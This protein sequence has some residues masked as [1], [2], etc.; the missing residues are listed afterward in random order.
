MSNPVKNLGREYLVNR[1]L[2]GLIISAFVF[3]VVYFSLY[4]FLPTSWQTPGSL[5]LYLIGVVGTLLLLV[6]ILFVFAK[7][8]INLGLPPVWYK[9]APYRARAVMDPR[10]VL[11][12]F[13]TEIGNGIEIKVWDST[14]EI[15]YLVL[16]EQHAGTEE[17]TEKKLSAIV[18]RNSMIGVE[19]ARLPG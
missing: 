9:S 3:L 16:Q 11:K 2:F 4:T 19:K 14:S 1:L 18:S 7:R 5:P 13:G 12:E 10:G 17:W 8:T 6:S 15:R